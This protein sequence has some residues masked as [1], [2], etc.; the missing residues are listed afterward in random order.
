MPDHTADAASSAPPLPRASLVQRVQQQMPAMIGVTLGLCISAAL[1]YITTRYEQRRTLSAFEAQVTGLEVP[2]QKGIAG[3][4]VVLGSVSRFYAA[5]QSVDRDEFREFHRDTWH[6]HPGIELLA[7]A[8]RVD[9]GRLKEYEARAVKEFKVDPGYWVRPLSHAPTTE[10]STTATNSDPVATAAVPLA[11]SA[12]PATSGRMVV[13]IQFI[14]PFEHHGDLLGVDI[15]GSAECRAAMDACSRS[16]SAAATPPLLLP[17]GTVLDTVLFLPIYTGEHGDPALREDADPSKDVA[18]F[19]IGAMRLRRL[20]Q[21]TLADLQTPGV[22]VGLYDVTTPGHPRLLYAT[23][24]GPSRSATYLLT[25][26]GAAAEAEDTDALI[27]ASAIPMAGRDWALVCSATPEFAA[28]RR[29]WLPWGVVLTSL[30]FTA[31]TT[32]YLIAITGR[33]ARITSVVAARTAELSRANKE[34]TGQVSARQQTEE[35]LRKSEAV[36]HSLVETLPQNIYRKDLSGHFTFCNTNFGRELQASPDDIVGRMDSDFFPRH[37]ADRYLQDDRRVIESGHTFQTVEEHVAPDGNKRYVEVIKTPVVR[38]DGKVM[39]TQGIFWD[40]TAREEAKRLLQEKNLQLE[41]AA[42]AER[43]AREAL[44]TAQAHMVQSEKLAALGQ[45]VAGVAHEINNPLAFVSN[46]VAV[47]QRDLKAIVDILKLYIQSDP[48]L[49]E[50]SPTLAAQIKDLADRTDLPYTIENV[51]DLL[52]R[53]RDGLKRIQQ[54][55][56]DLREF[57]RLDRSDYQDADVNAGVESTIN[58]IRGHAKKKQVQIET[59]FGQ[60]PP[61][62]CFPAKVNQVVMNLLTNAID[63][64]H[65]HGKVFVRTQANDGQVSIEVR[66]EGTGIPPDVR[67]RIFDPFFTTKPLGQGTG[68]GLSIS[69]G[70]IQDH[71]GRIELES[72]MGK[73]STFRVVLP[74]VGMAG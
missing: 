17:D 9:P 29:T 8:P 36:Y 37:L 42:R 13:P 27:R 55:V 67:E 2:L 30:L 57:A 56:K 69:Y 52:V 61:V 46:N 7:W 68:L 41:Q 65:E 10:P 34:L 6:Y 11:A 45:M 31:I 71:G 28:Q 49:A 26:A 60:L 21:T 23:P 64:S 51:D 1:F 18:G 15:A 14:E 5:S 22:D 72:E 74:V 43:E 54:I 47:L 62:R 44:Q 53:S 48:T 35:A 39:G 25:R 58:I 33:A 20:L 24:G 4:L 50:H 32:A 66:D 40:V 12:E 38:Q 63:A 3:D 16:G 19:A 59:Q 70:I 73:G